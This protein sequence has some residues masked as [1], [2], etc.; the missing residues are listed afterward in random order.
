[1]KRLAVLTS[2]SCFALAACGT[3]E[4]E[5]PSAEQTVE[6]AEAEAAATAE[7]AA[8]MQSIE[9]TDDPDELLAILEEQTMYTAAGK[10]ANAKL[11][12]VLEPRFAEADSDYDLFQLKKYTEVRGSTIRN[13]YDARELELAE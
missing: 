4:P 8:V 10:A 7:E 3:A 13:L 11:M 2:I 1:M 9:E 12:E 5:E 6:A